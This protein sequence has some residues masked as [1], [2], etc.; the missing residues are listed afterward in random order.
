MRRSLGAICFSLFTSCKTPAFYAEQP[1][2]S[3]DN[4][5]Y[6]LTRENERYQIQ[7]TS[8]QRYRVSEGVYKTNYPVFFICH[9]YYGDFIDLKVLI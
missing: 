9:E 8:G 2:I 7:F 1:P 5:G 6:V 3:E 4:K